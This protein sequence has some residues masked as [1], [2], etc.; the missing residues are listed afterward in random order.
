MPV[1][2]IV[3]VVSAVKLLH[4]KYR[5]VPVPPVTGP[6]P[7]STDVHVIAPHVK[8]SPTKMSLE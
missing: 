7:A 8:S 5:N 3:K 2:V 6:L 4:S 1:C